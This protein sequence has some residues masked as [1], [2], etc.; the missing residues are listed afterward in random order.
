VATVWDGVV[1][2]IWNLPENPSA[3]VAWARA[4]DVATVEIKTADGGASWVD[5]PGRHVSRPYCDALRAAGLRVLGWSY[6]YCDGVVDGGDRGD[7]VPQAEADAAAAAV[8]A[9]GLEGHSFDLEAECEGHPEAVAVMLAAARSLLPTVPLACDTWASRRGHADYPWEEIGAG[10]DVVRP[11]VYRP[12]WSMEAMYAEGDLGPWL[13]G[14]TV[15]PI[16][17]ITEPSTTVE[18]LDEDVLVGDE[19]GC[20][21]YG[22]WEYSGLPGQPGVIG[23]IRGLSDEVPAPEPEP[24]D[25]DAARDEVWSIAE[26]CEQAG[27]PWFGQGLKSVVA[28][29]KGEK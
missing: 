13:D 11:M 1:L 26:A 16:L 25:V 28:L 14:K 21:G 10:V 5:A 8:A 9:L 17:S 29:S 4:L 3:L 18:Q 20:V 2:T 24:F 6:N 7:G 15:A 22:I 23:W 27:Y 19:Q 12:S